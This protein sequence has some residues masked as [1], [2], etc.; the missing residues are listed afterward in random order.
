M[1]F[2]SKFSFHFKENLKKKEK[3][4]RSSPKCQRLL[5]CSLKPAPTNLSFFPLDILSLLASHFTRILRESTSRKDV[6]SVQSGDA[7]P[8]VPAKRCPGASWDVLLV[9]YARSSTSSEPRSKKTKPQTPEVFPTFG[10]REEKNDIFFFL[11]GGVFC[12]SPNLSGPL[13]R[14]FSSSF[15]AL[16]K[17]FP[18]CLSLQTWLNYRTVYRQCGC[19]ILTDVLIFNIFFFAYIIIHCSATDE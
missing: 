4:G 8:V 1:V 13:L 9:L 7:A 6:A 11:F 2:P 5:H 3:S 18:V 17:C 14:I 12:I 15:H 10:M 16:A 19:C